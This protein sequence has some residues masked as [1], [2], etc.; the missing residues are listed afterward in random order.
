MLV[1]GNEELEVDTSDPLAIRQVELLLMA[2]SFGELKREK[3]VDVV[4]IAATSREL[5]SSSSYSL[6]EEYSS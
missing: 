3:G 4:A 2:F 1:L 5:S 6:A